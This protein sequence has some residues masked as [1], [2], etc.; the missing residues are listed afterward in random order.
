MSS[1]PERGYEKASMA[2]DMF[3]M[4]DYLDIH[5]PVHV[6]GH[7]IGGMI[8]F[9][10]ASRRS[11]RVRSVCWGECHLP[12]T[13]AYEEDRAIPART[14]RQFH[15]VSHSVADL[16]E[17]LV[18]GKERIYV[19]HFLRKLTYNLAAFSESDIA[20]Y[21]REYSQPGS[22]R[23]AMNVYRAFEDDAKDNKHWLAQ[24][25]KCKVPTLILSGGRG[26][27][28]ESA[29]EMAL[30]LTEVGLVEAGVVEGADHYLAEE[31]PNGFCD[32]VIGFLR[33]C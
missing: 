17:A 23:C 20:F 31:N 11:E 10:M 8:A 4:L 18:L 13:R 1:K 15:F 30:E 24:H 9:A 19:E 29:E 16:L 32:V 33:R 26:W 7:D 27:H 5:E 6:V 22:M 12:G 21:A 25:G 3:A 14:I 28:R 2:E